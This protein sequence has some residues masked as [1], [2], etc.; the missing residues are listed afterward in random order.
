MLTM[1]VKSSLHGEQYNTFKVLVESK[2]EGLALERTWNSIQLTG[3]MTPP[4]PT[5]RHYSA[6]DFTTP[7]EQEL[8]E[9][10]VYSD[11]PTWK[12]TNDKKWEETL[13]RKTP[14]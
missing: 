1:T 12:Q 14:C 3:G 9:L 2:H 5:G 13:K 8:K 7:T 10:D 6:I 11:S 4:K